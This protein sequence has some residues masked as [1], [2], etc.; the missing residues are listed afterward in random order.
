MQ[1]AKWYNEIIKLEIPYCQ[2]TIL[3]SSHLCKIA[4]YPALTSQY[5][6]AAVMS[7][8]VGW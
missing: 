4:W 7:R 3:C 8:F 6:R 5:Q 1:I 2:L